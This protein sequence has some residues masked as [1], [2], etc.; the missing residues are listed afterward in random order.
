MKLIP[1]YFGC[2]REAGHYLFTVG[3]ESLGARRNS[4]RDLETFIDGSF[5][6]T[7]LPQSQQEG[8]ANLTHMNRDYH[9]LTILSFWDRSVDSRPGSNSN[10]ILP[11]VLN[12]QQAL[13][14]SKKQFPKVFSR[15]K[16]EVTEWKKW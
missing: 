4:Y 7:G 15:F 13:E 8:V 2:H 5:C 12:F 11:G 1:L 6:P 16:F 10:F 3:M 9:G 14:E